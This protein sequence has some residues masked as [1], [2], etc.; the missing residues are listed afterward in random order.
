MSR[1]EILRAHYVGVARRFT[2]WLGLAS[3]LA[4]SLVSGP[5]NAVGAQITNRSTT[6]GSSVLS[7]STTYDFSFKPATS[8]TIKA[9]KFETCTSPLETTTCSTVTGASMSTGSGFSSAAPTTVPFTTNWAVATGSAAPSANAY[10]IHYATG[11]ALSNA[12]TY[13]VRLTSI[14]NPSTTN[15]QY[16]T[17][18]TTYSDD[19]AG[20]PA[21]TE[22]DFGAM[23]VSTARSIGVSANVQESLAFC[24][25]TSGTGCSGGGLTGATVN[26]GTGTDNVLSASTPSGGISLM[27]VDTNASSG[28]AITYVTTSPGGAS[29]TQCVGGLSSTTD[30]ITEA[31]ATAGTFTAG[32]SKFGINLKTNT[33]ALTTP[34]L[35][36]NVSGSGS[37]TASGQYAIADNVAFQAGSTPRTV[38][39]AAGPTLSNLFT[40]TYVAQAGSTTK[41]GAYSA[42]FIW[43]ATGTF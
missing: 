28:Y 1:G 31:G 13:T 9:I 6:L 29:G 20:A 35:G 10:W 32:T 37:G 25:G 16:Y 30:C 23:A 21:V 12:T 27:A 42:T 18:I 22:V 40:V 43:V 3:I 38:A 7:A 33:T 39:S 8:A 19:A 36:A 4:F 11:N 24:V 5:A 14:V 17:R 15:L 26:L 34:A 2:A 41:P